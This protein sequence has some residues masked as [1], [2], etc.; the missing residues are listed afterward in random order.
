MNILHAGT[1]YFANA[2]S[3]MGHTVITGGILES[4]DLR[5]THP[6][7]WRTLENK[8]QSGGFKPDLFIYADNG[9]LP[10][11]VDPENIPCYSIFYSIDTYC[12]PWHVPYGHGF[13]FC[14]VA[15]KDYLPLFVDDGQKACWMPLFVQA[16]SNIPHMERDIPVSFVGTLGHKNN[17]DRKPF[18]LAFNE[19]QPL[20]ILSGDFR[21]IFAQSKIVLNQTAIGE[22][23]F[24]CFEAMACGAAL[25]MEKCDNGLLEIFTPGIDILPLFTRNRARE[26][27]SIA[28]IYLK[29]PDA[30]A[31]IAKKGH[32]L[33]MCKHTDFTRA[34]KILLDFSKYSQENISSARLANPEAFGCF[35][36]TAFGM[37]AVELQGEQWERYRELFARIAR[38]NDY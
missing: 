25:L 34:E 4:S 24:R 15:Q 3:R 8:L 23:N 38:G 6:A 9:N 16:D 7:S 29:R 22:V 12:N 1:P 27:A 26:A 36:R 30:L 10:Y 17:P 21:Q 37:I 28:S 31:R 13:D 14:Y 32:E 11:I 19:Y 5:I 33:V 20:R 2:F 18:L 35:T